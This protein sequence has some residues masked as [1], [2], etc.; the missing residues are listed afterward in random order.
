M[1]IPTEQF[2][3]TFPQ[4]LLEA[5]SCN[6]QIIIPNVSRTFTDGIDDIKQCINYHINI[7]DKFLCNKNTILNHNNFHNFYLR[8]FNNNFYYQHIKYY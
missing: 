2:F 3:E 7:N 1:H 5:I 8:L 4:T 6:K